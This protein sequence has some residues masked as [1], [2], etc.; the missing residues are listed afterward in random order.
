[1]HEISAPGCILVSP[2]PDDISILIQQAH[3]IFP[4]AGI[5]DEWCLERS[6]AGLDKIGRIDISL[7]G[8]LL[9]VREIYFITPQHGACTYPVDM[10]NLNE[11]L[12]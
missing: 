1:V 10:A 6:I 9:V 8:E 4:A 2:N 12:N 3:F 11:K 5:H 7:V